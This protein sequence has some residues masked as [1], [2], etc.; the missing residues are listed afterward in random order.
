MW[1]HNKSGVTGV[2]WS[3]SSKKWEAYINVEKK[4]RHIGL[5]SDLE[6]AI[7]ARAAAEKGQGYTKRHG[8]LSESQ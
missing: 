7:K 6:S 1:G 3:K 4:Q 8:K 5:F 2:C